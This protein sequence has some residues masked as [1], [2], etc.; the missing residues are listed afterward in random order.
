MWNND[1]P[2]RTSTPAHRQWRRA[3]LERDGHRC[4][5]RYPNRCTGNATEADHIIEV[6]DGGPEL[7]L[8]NGQAACTP[9][10]KHKTALHANRKRWTS[11]N[12]KPDE[13][14]PALR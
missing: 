8:A 4:Q 5:L 9:C 13:T 10:H 7:D 6:A 1:T 14:H 12:L 3:V 2:S 11:R